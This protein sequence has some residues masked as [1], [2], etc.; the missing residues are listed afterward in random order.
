MPLN[1]TKLGLLIALMWPRAAGAALL[2]AVSEQLNGQP[3]ADFQANTIDGQAVTL[4]DLHG[5]PVVVNFFASWCP[6]CQMEIGKLRELEPDF[7]ARGLSVIG[8]LVDPVETP[9]TVDEA[10]RGLRENP[11]P[12]PV[13]M[14]TQALRDVFQYQG[15]PATY[16]ITAVGTFSTALLGN[17]PIE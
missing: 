13:L 6:A 10:L 16:F 15:F 2:P 3:V 8:V 1:L 17:H 12:Y 11:L 5:T 14:M 9:D 4:G 7:R